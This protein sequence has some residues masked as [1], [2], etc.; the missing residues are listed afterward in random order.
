MHGCGVFYQKDA[1]VYLVIEKNGALAN[2]GI[3]A[4]CTHMGCVVPWDVPKEDKFM[5]PCHGS[6]YDN[7]G[8]VV[9]GPAPLSLALQHVDVVNGKVAISPWLETDFRDGEAPWWAE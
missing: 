2:Y 5:C 4:I 8:Q 3:N 6:Q 1:P 7:R 9:Q